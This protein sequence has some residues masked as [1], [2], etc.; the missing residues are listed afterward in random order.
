MVA[1]EDPEWSVEQAFNAF[2]RFGRG[3]RG[4]NAFLGVWSDWIEPDESTDFGVLDMPVIARSY[5]E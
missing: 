1:R 4:S 5:E 2:T 3:K